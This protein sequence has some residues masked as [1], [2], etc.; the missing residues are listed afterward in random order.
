LATPVMIKKGFIQSPATTDSITVIGS[1]VVTQITVTN[2]GSHNNTF[3]IFRTPAD[4]LI[5]NSIFQNDCRIRKDVTIG[6]GQ[7]VILD[8]LKWVLSN[9]D[10]IGISKTDAGTGRDLIFYI[11]GVFV[12]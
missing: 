3:S 11:D 8:N 6:A 9:G 5:S 12:G 2:I 1:H 4:E 10:A 7:T